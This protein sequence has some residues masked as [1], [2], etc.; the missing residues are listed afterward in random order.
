[1]AERVRSIPACLPRS[2][3]RILAPSDVFCSSSKKQK[4][5]YGNELKNGRYTTDSLDFSPILDDSRS[6]H[7]VEGGNRNELTNP[8]Y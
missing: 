2:H 5:F 8:T 7:V 1:M 6:Y 4:D 3:T